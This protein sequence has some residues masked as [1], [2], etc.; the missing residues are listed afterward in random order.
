MISG[1][2]GSV[3]SPQQS[4]PLQRT[5]SGSD[6][7]RFS[8]N[9]ISHDTDNPAA[10]QT[11]EEKYME[12]Y[13][14]VYSVNRAFVGGQKEVFSQDLRNPPCISSSKSH[15]KIE[16]GEKVDDAGKM[17]RTLRKPDFMVQG[18]CL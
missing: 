14:Q 18:E 17:V 8:S 3:K 10:S 1:S 9:R 7:P 15:R 2:Q 13:N 12:S 5:D 11:Y 16:V 6:N 4:T